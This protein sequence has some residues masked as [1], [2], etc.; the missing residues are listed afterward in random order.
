[1]AELIRIKIE[2]YPEIIF[3]KDEH[4]YTPLTEYHLSKQIPNFKYLTISAKKR[5]RRKWEETCEIHREATVSPY[6]PPRWMKSNSS[7]QVGAALLLRLPELFRTPDPGL[8]LLANTL[9]GLHATALHKAEPA[10]SPALSINISGENSIKLLRTILKPAAPP[11]HWHK[12]CC[13]IRQKPVLDYRKGSSDFS[14]RLIEFSSIRCKKAVA[15][16]PFTDT[17]LMVLGANRAQMREL[18]PYLHRAAVLLINCASTPELAP[19]HI[20]ASSI[21][22]CDEALIHLWETHKHEIASV[23]GWW[24][25]LIEDEQG[26]TARIVREARASFGTPDSR[27]VRVEFDPLKLRSAIFHRVLLDFLSALRHASI[28]PSEEIDRHYAQIQAVLNPVP[29]EKEPVRRADDP[30]AFL[31]I[32]RELVREQSNKI[33]PSTERFVKGDKLLAAWRVISG[34]EYLVIPE[35]GWASAYKRA[36]RKEKDIDATFFERENWQRDF[37]RILCE[38]NVIKAPA[39]GYRYRYDFFENGSRDTTYVLAIPS[40]LLKS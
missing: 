30:E 17:A 15:P 31:A 1:M 21:S 33:L 39:A 20:A 25:G 6:Q 26:W 13:S 9:C 11:K 8:Q 10:F 34:E 32:M 4:G 14:C 27:Y 38:A 18:E 5:L 3:I 36:V 19:T 35:A 40:K 24:W 16:Y 12:K 29:K 23:L 2:S 22:E 37:Q 7:P 28:L